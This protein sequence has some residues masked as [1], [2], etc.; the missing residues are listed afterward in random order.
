MAKFFS[1]NIG[2]TGRLLRLLWGLLLTGGGIAAW[3]WHWWAGALLVALGLF[4]FFEALRGWCL[5]RACG[6]KTKW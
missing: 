6:I 1:P 3:T 5:V 2:R 4:A